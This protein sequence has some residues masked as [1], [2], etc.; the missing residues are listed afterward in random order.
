MSKTRI[1]FYDPMIKEDIIRQ[2]YPKYTIT[3]GYIFIDSYEHITNKLTILEKGNNHIHYGKLVE[4]DIDL[5]TIIT[6]MIKQ[7]LIMEN[8]EIKQIY[9]DKFGSGVCKAHI[10]LNK[11]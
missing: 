2:I 11:N 8:H 9:V 7:E 4:Y 5:K 3:N 6:N 10:I 1:F